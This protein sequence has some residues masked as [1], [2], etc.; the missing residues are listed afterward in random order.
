MN[1]HHIDYP[2]ISTAMPEELIAVITDPGTRDIVHIAENIEGAYQKVL[3][4]MR[5]VLAEF[6][7]EFRPI[8]GHKGYILSGFKC[9]VAGCP[10]CP[11]G[12]FWR[13]VTCRRVKVPEEPGQPESGMT[14]TQLDRSGFQ[15]TMPMPLSQAIPEPE[16]SEA[17]EGPRRQTTI[18]S[19]TPKPLTS[20]P[21]GLFAQRHRPP[22]D[23]PQNFRPHPHPVLRLNNQR[24]ALSEFRERIRYMNASLRKNSLFAELR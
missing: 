23:T 15:E 21:G 14:K 20:L 17:G 3:Q 4:D 10:D 18:F 13:K 12:V 19:P 2:V 24:E 5:D 9:G 7:R 22:D 11:H 6:H 8:P 16:P 1:R